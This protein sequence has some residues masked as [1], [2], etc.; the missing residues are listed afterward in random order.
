MAKTQRKLKNLLL[1][2]GIQVPAALLVILAG[3]LF[4]NAL[5]FYKF[6]KGNYEIFFQSYPTDA[7]EFIDLK[8]NDL[9]SF[10]LILIAIS[11]VTTIV[12]AVYALVI[13]HRTAGAGFRIQAVI[14]EIKSGNVDS[15]INLRKNDELQDLAQSFN[16]LMDQVDKKV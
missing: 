12:L 16:E 7:Q 15:R 2:K 14:E 11:A 6:V 9:Q 4:S 13:S 8:F 3:I 5:L 10:I 1:N